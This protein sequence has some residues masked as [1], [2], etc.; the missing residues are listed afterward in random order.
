MKRCIQTSSIRFLAAF[1]SLLT[2]PASATV[3]SV[4]IQSPYLTGG[5]TSLTSPVHVQATAESGLAITGYVVYVDNN[6]YFQN[7]SASM[8]AWVDITKGTHTVYVRA[9]DSGGSFATSTTYNINVTGYA[10]PTPPPG[11]T[12]VNG[13]ED[14]TW[15]TDTNSDVGGNC[16][17]GKI[18]GY[19]SSSD[20]NTDNDPDQDSNGQHFQL[21]ST[22]QYDDTLFYYK[23]GT[24]NFSADTNLLWDYWFYVPTTTSSSNIQALEFDMFQAVQ[25]SDGVHEFMF[26][27]Q[28]LYTSNVWQIWISNTWTTV[29]NSPCEFSSGGW[30][31]VT[32][33]V[34]RVTSSGYQNLPATFSSTSDTNSYMR[35][36]TLTVDGDTVPLTDVGFNGLSNSTIPSPPWNPVLGVQHQ[37]DSRTSGITL[38]E[39]ADQE[40]VTAW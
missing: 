2:L 22:C 25:L 30:H 14:L 9:W 34:Q 3:T 1:V 4:S 28:C 12:H 38:D 13:I 18:V 6:N 10:P 8:D 21:T 24:G 23:D 35:F 32:Y 26:G 40:S 29:P 31:H 5:T 37:L 11:A 39:Y 27:T 33:F 15:T 7:H 19:Q 36:V 17:T 20:P 16:Q